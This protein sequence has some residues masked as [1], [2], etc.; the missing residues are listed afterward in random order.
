VAAEIGGAVGQ[1]HA[2]QLALEEAAVEPARPVGADERARDLADRRRVVVDRHLL[3]ERQRLVGDVQD[4]ERA[5][6]DDRAEVVGDLDPRP[7]H[8]LVADEA[9]RHAGQ[10][11][12]R[13]G[14]QPARVERLPDPVRVVGD[15][16]LVDALVLEDRDE[17]VV[18]RQ[19]ERAHR[20]VTGRAAGQ[21]LGRGDGHRRAVGGDVDDHEVAVVRRAEAGDPD[22]HV[23][24]EALG[25]EV[26]EVGVAS[27]ASDHAR[28][29]GRARDGDLALEGLRGLEAAD[30]LE[31]QAR[32][33]RV[34]V[35]LQVD[36][37]VGDDRDLHLRRRLAVQPQLVGV[38]RARH[39]ACRAASGDDRLAVALEHPYAR[40]LVV[41]H[42]DVEARVDGV[43]GRHEHARL[44]R[45]VLRERVLFDELQRLAAVDD[46]GDVVDAAVLA[47]A[48]DRDR[49]AGR[50]AEGRPVGARCED[51]VAGAIVR[52]GRGAGE[53][54]A[55]DDRAVL[56]IGGGL[57]DRVRDRRV[58]R[59]LRREVVASVERDDDG[60]VPVARA[61]GDL[62]RLGRIEGRRARRRIARGH[63]RV[64][65]EIEAPAETFAHG[66]QAK[67][68]LL[69]GANSQEGFYPAIL[70]DRS[71]TPGNYRAAL[72]TLF[73]DRADEALRL[74]PGA[75]A[76]EVKRSATALAGDLFIAHSTWRWMDLHRHTGGQSVYFY[77]YAHPRPAKRDPAPGKQPDPGAVHSGE[78]E[79]ALGNLD[80][81]QVY[82]WTPVDRAV[83]RT[84][85]DYFAQF[86][87]S[88]D[89]NQA[90]LPA[91]PAVRNEHGGITRQTI[92]ADTRTEIDRG[93]ARQAFLREF[94][95]GHQSPL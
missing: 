6:G 76:E 39:A 20:Q 4:R 83:S 87:R 56:R 23:L 30:L 60:D 78:I 95:A 91:W 38:V 74:Y 52:E 77:Y 25:D 1:R 19:R 24:H 8:E 70:H 33:E 75:T 17:D 3:V 43:R 34:A 64:P 63:R 61:E 12:G 66:D 92:D 42:H 10:R 84:M 71:P 9:P 14:A 85:Q 82:A 93:A 13:A 51:R 44:V 40:V 48:G 86:V 29:G 90:G 36:L 59:I 89:P 57:V 65:V 5:A 47:D 62:V 31:L 55:R 32:I 15:V 53:R 50:E 26:A 28:A 2:D 22:P 72:G 88:G 67:V 16:A 11:E 94:L 21:R 37:A 49:L 68:P 58:V 35:V 80:G 79:Y 81:N 69:V 18:R 41:E 46:V 27:G 7:D 45:E 54:A 73:G